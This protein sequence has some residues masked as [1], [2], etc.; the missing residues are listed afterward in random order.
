MVCVYIYSVY[1]TVDGIKFCYSGKLYVY[2]LRS[3]KTPKEVVD[4]HQSAVTCLAPQHSTKVNC[5]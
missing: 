4:A 2:E 3:V 5:T 1:V